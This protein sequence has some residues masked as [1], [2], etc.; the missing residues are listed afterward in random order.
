MLQRDEPILDNP[1]IWNLKLTSVLQSVQ[2]S[3]YKQY[4]ILIAWSKLGQC[5][6]KTTLHLLRSRKH[7]ARSLL[8]LITSLMRNIKA[9]KVCYRLFYWKSS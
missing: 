2:Q 6:L 7:A 5:Q 3:L 4:N 9:I 8:P 1:L